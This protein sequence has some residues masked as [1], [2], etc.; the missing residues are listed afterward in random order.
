MCPSFYIYRET[1][2]KNQINDKLTVQ[3]NA[4]FRSIVYEDPYRG[5]GSLTVSQLESKLS[6]G[7]LFTPAEVK[8]AP[9]QKAIH[10]L[11]MGQQAAKRTVSKNSKMFS[12]S[13]F[14]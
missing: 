6:C 1:E 2:A 5:L 14:A 4:I 7:K 8:A 13:N 9:R 3:N 11:H 10:Y 12:G